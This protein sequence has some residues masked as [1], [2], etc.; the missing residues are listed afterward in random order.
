MTLPSYLHARVEELDSSSAESDYSDLEA[1]SRSLQRLAT[2]SNGFSQASVNKS[3]KL[4]QNLKNLIS[5]LEEKDSGQSLQVEDG[6]DIVMRMVEDFGLMSESDSDDELEN[7]DQV[8]C[9]VCVVQ[10]RDFILQHFL[11]C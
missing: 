7:L 10:S 4:N 2:L 1:S 5:G 11:D 6:G 9:S 3:R 8:L